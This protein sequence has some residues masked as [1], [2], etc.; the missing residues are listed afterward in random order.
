M[1]GG[2]ESARRSWNLWAHQSHK[3]C[4]MVLLLHRHLPRCP[5]CLIWLDQTREC[6]NFLCTFSAIFVNWLHQLSCLDHLL[7]RRLQRTRLKFKFS[8]PLPR[9]P[10]KRRTRHKELRTKCHWPK[11]R[12]NPWQNQ[13]E[14]VRRRHGF[15]DFSWETP[16]YPSFRRCKR[17][18]LLHL[19]CIICIAWCYFPLLLAYDEEVCSAW[20]WVPW[21]Q[22][23]CRRSQG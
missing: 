6:S 15:W 10:Q 20:H 21:V 2:K 9:R 23:S 16:W 11:P 17:I 1:K 5:L 14:N 3:M 22:G 19:R 8:H 18:S 13:G 4:P 7:A 12:W